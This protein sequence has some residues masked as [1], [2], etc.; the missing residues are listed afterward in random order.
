MRL[1]WKVGVVAPIPENGRLR[2]EDCEFE[3]CLGS[4]TR[5]CLEKKMMQETEP[6][7]LSADNMRP[8]GR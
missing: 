2:Q 4:I 7:G 3:S 8:K 5:C 1:Q 6:I